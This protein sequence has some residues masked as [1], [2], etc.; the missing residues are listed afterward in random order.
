MKF[1]LNNNLFCSPIANSSNK[2]VAYSCNTGRNTENFEATETSETPKVEPPPKNFNGWM[3]YQGIDGYSAGG[4]SQ[5]KGVIQI[6]EHNFAGNYLLE[7]GNKP[8]NYGAKDS[9]FIIIVAGPQIPKGTYVINYG[10]K[11]IQYS[12]FTMNTTEFRTNG[13]FIQSSYIVVYFAII[14]TDSNA[15]TKITNMFNQLYNNNGGW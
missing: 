15:V 7:S 2:I 3:K 8:D 6:G 14:K 10:N 9:P 13:N 11:G 4:F 1:N 12:S 5:D